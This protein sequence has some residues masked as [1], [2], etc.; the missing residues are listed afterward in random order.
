M[1]TYL[2][3]MLRILSFEEE[4]YREVIVRDKLSLVYTAVNVAGFGALYGLSA[5]YFSSVLVESGQTAPL[6]GRLQLTLFLMGISISFLIHGGVALLSWGFCRGFGGSTLFLPIYLALGMA[7]IALWPM[8][9]VLAAFQVQKT[10]GLF[11]PLAALALAMAFGVVFRALK[12]ASGLG[13]WRMCLVGVV[14]LVYIGCFL[15]LW[16]G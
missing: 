2:S 6:T 14:I 1:T 12:S 3:H 16:V 15:Y 8:A 13:F 10:G 4:V 5:L 11:Y 7:W 9:P